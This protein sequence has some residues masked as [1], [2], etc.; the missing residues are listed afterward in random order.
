MLAVVALWIAG[1]GVQDLAT[2]ADAVTSLGRLTGLVSANLL[3]VQVLLMARVP[4]VERTYGQ[5]EL[6]RRHRLVGLWS[7][8]LMLAHLVLISVGYALSVGLNPFAEFWELVVDYPGMLLALAGTL[9]LVL[10]VATSVR[11][12]RRRL[13]YESWHLLHLYAYLGVGL[14][15]PHM[16]WTGQDFVS[17]PAATAY[18]WTLWGTA[19]GSI[20]VW[21]VG[22]P[23]VRSLWHDL[24]VAEVTQ[25]SPDV[26]TVLVRGRRL[27]RLP[28]AAGQFFTWRFVTG[29]GWTRGHPYSLSATPDGECLRITVKDLG[30]GS[31]ALATVRPGARVLIEGPY[32]RLHAGV[33]TRRK[34][35]LLASGIGISPMRALLE[36]LPQQ[37]GDVTLIYRARTEADLVLRAEIEQLAQA[38]GARVFYVLG[39]RV[40]GR[41]TW[42]PESAAALSDADALRRL[43]PDIA[44]QDVY[45][46][47]A[48]EWMDAAECAARECG[49]P[50]SRIHS[51]R[52]SW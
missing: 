25:E 21:R 51:E 41:H 6:A 20:L 39:R 52:F 44:E 15:I 13:R 7:F 29:S 17:S 40:R 34:V 19:A 3:L 14:A 8:N 26:T 46:C 47:G 45:L 28:A 37:P 42:L 23:L 27:D 22:L 48:T 38:R 18:W 33:R 30:D 31:R 4:V 24:R 1:H 43:V 35:T 16:L 10:V 11:R 50:A 12:A 49:V 36:G 2:P 9:L 5:D 32:G